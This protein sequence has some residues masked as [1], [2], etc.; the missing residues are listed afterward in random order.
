MNENHCI[1]TEMLLMIDSKGS[2][3]KKWTS[4]SGNGLAP[5]GNKPLPEPIVSNVCVAI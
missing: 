2:I 1:L 5:W 4:D 3:N